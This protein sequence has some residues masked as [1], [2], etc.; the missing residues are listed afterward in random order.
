MRKLMLAIAL[1]VAL[2]GAIGLGSAHALSAAQPVVA[3]HT[4]LL[5]SGSPTPYGPVC[6]G[7][8][9]TGCGG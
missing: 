8:S 9:S 4:H 3:A 2:L 7:G 6:P 1:I 5:V